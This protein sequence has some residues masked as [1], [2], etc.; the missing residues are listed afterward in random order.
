[1]KIL[2]L[3]IT[4]AAILLSCGNSSTDSKKASG[5]DKEAVANN[6]TITDD[7]LYPFLLGGVYIFHGYGG[8]KETQEKLIK[9]QMEKKPGDDGFLNELHKMY[10]NYF[11][12]PFK[13][14][15]GGSKETLAEYW[16]ITDKASFLKTQAELLTNGHQS[17]YLALSASGATAKTPDEK[18]QVAFIQAHKT[19]FPKQGIKAWDIARY[20]N[21]TAIGFA[22]GY[23]TKNESDAALAKLQ[24]LVS[25]QFSNWDEYWKS[26]NLG[27][28]F[29]A[30]DAE[31][32]A[33]FDNTSKE[34]LQGDYSIYKYVKL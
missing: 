23:L 19:E 14:E 3:I 12:Y 15:D 4:L 21:N 1:M 9:D 25:G 2:V 6:N 34:M 30:G 13:P 8:G 26:Y 28:K 20:V 31:H 10:S 33:E 17:K 24:P 18:E 22:A 29:W 27:R 7:Q 16:D 32:D 5:S 11:M